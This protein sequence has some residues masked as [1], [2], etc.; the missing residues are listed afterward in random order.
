[1]SMIRVVNVSQ[2]YGIRPV[3][4]NIDME[5][6]P[7]ELVA[8][9]G[10]NG[11]GK[12][13]LLMVMAGALP[14]LKGYVE[15]DGKRRRSSEEDELAIRRKTVYL[16]AD[17]W[18]PEAMTGREYLLAVGRLYDVDDEELMDHADRVLKLF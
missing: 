5:V 6:E 8:V 2:H 3:L 15:I 17:P 11:M 16:P 9:M 18:M 7:G 12:T 1:M 13:S 14:P 10:P 4:R